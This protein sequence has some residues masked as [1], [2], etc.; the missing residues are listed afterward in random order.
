YAQVARAGL[1]VPFEVTVHRQG[2]FD[3][4]IVLAVSNDY[5]GIFDQNAKS[6]EPVEETGSDREI[7][8][9]FDPP[10]G[11]TFTFSLDA[12]VQGSR[13]WGRSG[14]VRLLDEAGSQLAQVKFKTWLAP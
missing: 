14:L 8:W 10:E 12:R 9:R 11:E 4:K 3:Q 13:H 1:S 7:E 5:L 6:P 2:G